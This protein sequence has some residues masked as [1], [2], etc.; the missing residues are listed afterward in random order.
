ML[1]RLTLTLLLCV[2]NAWCSV[3]QGDGGINRGQEQWRGHSVCVDNNSA[4]RDEVN[5]CRFSKVARGPNQFS[6][7]ASKVVDGKEV[8]MGSPAWK[9]D[10]EK[11]GLES[12]ASA[13]RLVVNGNRMEGTVTLPGGAVYRRIYLMK[14]TVVS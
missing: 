5:G 2:S 9:F 7:T 11:R 14:K 13:I 6:A 8:V 3:S 4:C 1:T 10:D 12:Q